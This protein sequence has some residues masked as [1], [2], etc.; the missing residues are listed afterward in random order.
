MNAMWS[1]DDKETWYD[2]I[3]KASGQRVYDYLIRCGIMKV[4]DFVNGKLICEKCD[5]WMIIVET[6]WNETKWKDW[7]NE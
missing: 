4:M 6:I 7:D 1:D 3:I 2:V 5:I